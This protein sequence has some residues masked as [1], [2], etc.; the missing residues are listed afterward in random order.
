M[1]AGANEKPQRNRAVRYRDPDYHSHS[2][3]D[4]TQDLVDQLVDRTT[5]CSKIELERR[6]AFF[7]KQGESKGGIARS[8][9][10][11]NNPKEVD[12]DI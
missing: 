1:W 3:D 2:D 4:M 8:L 11:T 12:Y 9:I 10:L 5:G 6:K 7:L